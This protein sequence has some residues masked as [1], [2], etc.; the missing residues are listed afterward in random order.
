MLFDLTQMAVLYAAFMA[1][2]GSRPSIDLVTLVVGY[3]IGVL[4]SVVAITPQGVG[5]T[6]IRLIGYFAMP[7]QSSMLA[8]V[9]VL[10]YRGLSFWQPLLV[11]IVALRWVG[12][13]VVGGR[14]NA[15]R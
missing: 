6:E 2:S 1:F 11:G 12:Q 13:P 8:T 3:T 14:L 7:L 5:V 4:F 9:G 10:A 15:E